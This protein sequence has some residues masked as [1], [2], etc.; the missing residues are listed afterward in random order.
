MGSKTEANA[1]REA[2]QNKKELVAADEI[3]STSD[4]LGLVEDKMVR[5]G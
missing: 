4:L 2:R 5:P 3:I 1:G